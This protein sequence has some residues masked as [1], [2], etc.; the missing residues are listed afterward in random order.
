MNNLAKFCPRG[1]E[2]LPPSSLTY[3]TPRLKNM[4]QIGKPSTPFQKCFMKLIIL[5]LSKA[6]KNQ[7][8]MNALKK[9]LLK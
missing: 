2:P 3:P 4:T 9:T 7:L 5:N 8:K 6:S 1:Q